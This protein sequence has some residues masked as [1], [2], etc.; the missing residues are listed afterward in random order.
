MRKSDIIKQRITKMSSGV[1]LILNTKNNNKYV[2]SSVDLS[3]R[4][5][6]HIQRLNNQSHA[7]SRLQRAWNKY[8]EDTFSF[9]VL[10]MCAKEKKSLLSLEQFYMDLLRPEYNILPTAGSPLG[11]THTEE[12]KAKIGKA[13]RGNQ[14]CLGHKHSAEAKAKMSAALRGRK[15]TAKHKANISRARMGMKLTDEHKVKLSKANRGHKVTEETKAKIS[16][17]LKG[18]APWNKGRTLT[19]LTTEHRSKLS[20]ANK[21]KPWSEAR[22][23]AEDIRQAKTNTLESK[24]D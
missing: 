24:D 14:Y 22:R 3:S 2:G 15:Y 16:A 12:T 23:A 4:E 19:A 20:V 8:G 7:N 11:F 21:G 18:K 9:H 1:Y 13:T 10:A 6:R 5:K 17:A